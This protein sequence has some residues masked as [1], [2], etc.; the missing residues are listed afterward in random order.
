MSRSGRSVRAGKPQE[1]ST[2]PSIR[3]DFVRLYSQL[4]RQGCDGRAPRFLHA[5]ELDASDFLRGEVRLEA[6]EG[7][8]SHEAKSAQRA[9]E[10]RVF[11][12]AKLSAGAQ[13]VSVG[14]RRAIPVQRTRDHGEAHD[15]TIKLGCVGSIAGEDT[16]G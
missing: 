4:F 10:R 1:T 11:L 5:S 8:A 13:G 15:E 3:C 6:V 7:E 12:H 16:C 9:S 14:V 2:P